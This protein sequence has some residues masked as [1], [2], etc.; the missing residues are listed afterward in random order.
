M[1]VLI[2]FE[3]PKLLS[4][5]VAFM[6]QNNL[7]ESWCQNK[8]NYLMKIQ[9]WSICSLIACEEWSWLLRA[10][11]AE[12]NLK[13]VCRNFWNFQTAILTSLISLAWL[14]VCLIEWMKQMHSVLLI[15]V[16]LRFKYK[17]EACSVRTTI[18]QRMNNRCERKNGWYIT[19][20]SVLAI[21]TPCRPW[22]RHIS[23]NGGRRRQLKRSPQSPYYYTY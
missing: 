11:R 22:F 20:L 4:K 17:T 2:R 5:C 12:K 8:A 10:K 18:S 3:A 6:G 7:L 9:F 14:T 13:I 23:L 15:F 16:S 1:C 19:A 21:R